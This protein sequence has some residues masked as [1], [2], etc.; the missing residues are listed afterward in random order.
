VRA[1]RQP[2]AHTARG[3]PGFVLSAG[4]LVIH[5]SATT[6]AADSFTLSGT[7]TNGC[8]LLS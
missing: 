7:Q 3:E 6:G 8:Q 4:L 1:I 5:Y 2:P